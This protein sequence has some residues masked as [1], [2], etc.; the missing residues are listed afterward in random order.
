MCVVCVQV[1]VCGCGTCVWCGMRGV[2]CGMCVR[3]DVCEY[4]VCVWCMSEM[5]VYVCVTC[6]REGVERTA[7]KI[8]HS[9]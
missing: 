6:I 7:D 4:C 9:D 8:M 3:V 1:R 2:W 5:C